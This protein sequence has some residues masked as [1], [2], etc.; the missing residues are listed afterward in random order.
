MCAV[1]PMVHTSKTSSCQKNFFSFISLGRSFGFLV[2][3]IRNHGEH[4]ETP[5]MKVRYVKKVLKPEL[6]G[7]DN[8]TLQL[9]S[10]GFATLPVVPHSEGQKKSR[11]PTDNC[12]TH[13]STSF[14]NS[15]TEGRN[16][17]AFRNFVFRSEC[18]AP[19]HRS[20]QPHHLQH[21][22]NF[23]FNLFATADQL[24]RQV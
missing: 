18:N 12:C 9:G 5:C 11:K 7:V 16:R 14:H 6:N 20:H 4:Y 21:S 23:R 2:I 3:N 17:S 22:P 19:D 1:S 10:F 24:A 13:R 8:G 15:K